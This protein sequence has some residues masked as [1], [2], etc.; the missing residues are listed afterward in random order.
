MILEGLTFPQPH[1]QSELLT[2]SKST[3]IELIMASHWGKT[4]RMNH[5]AQVCPRLSCS[6][7]KQRQEDAAGRSSTGGS[8]R[9]G[10]GSRTSGRRGSG[11]RGKVLVI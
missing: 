6:H 11:R 3:I 8:G 4:K 1:F 10:S 7:Q 9:R 5:P 2:A